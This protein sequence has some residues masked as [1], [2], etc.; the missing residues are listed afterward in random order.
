MVAGRI[1]VAVG[2]QPGWGAVNVDIPPEPVGSIVSRVRVERSDD[3]HWDDIAMSIDL[4]VGADSDVVESG[5]GGVSGTIE[6]RA[7]H[8]FCSGFRMEEV[9]PG[10][11]C[12]I[13]L[14]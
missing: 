5:R 7:C 3:A 2:R 11:V 12:F 1:H 9:R 8:E 14:L 6:S 10:V 13:D 4:D